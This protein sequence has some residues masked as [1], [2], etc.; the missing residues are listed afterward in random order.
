VLPPARG[1]DDLLLKWW[2]WRGGTSVSRRGVSCNKRKGVLNEGGTQSS[3][4]ELGYNCLHERKL[5]LLKASF[6]SAHSVENGDSMGHRTRTLTHKKEIL[7]MGKR[8]GSLTVSSAENLL[9]YGGKTRETGEIEKTNLIET[10]SPPPRGK[11]GKKKPTDDRRGSKDRDF[12]TDK[13]LGPGGGEDA[14]IHPTRA[15]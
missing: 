8:I 10:P 15:V 13:D 5:W 11:A 14:Q 6:L 1:E 9:E 12:L 2:S 7:E 3:R 4:K